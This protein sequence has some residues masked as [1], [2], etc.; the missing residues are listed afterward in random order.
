M[1]CELGT[2]YK[3]APAGAYHRE[4][5]TNEYF[6]NVADRLE[7]AEKRGGDNEFLREVYVRAELENIRNDL[8]FNNV[9]W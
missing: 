2:S 6:K 5:H 9:I 4:I 7:I 8:L 1:N 3:L